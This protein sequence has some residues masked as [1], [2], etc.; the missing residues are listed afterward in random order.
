MADLVA[1][2]PEKADNALASYL[3]AKALLLQASTR[4]LGSFIAKEFVTEMQR[5]TLAL[6]QGLSEQ[7]V[8]A[9]AKFDEASRRF[10]VMAREGGIELAAEY[11]NAL[12]EDVALLDPLF[13]EKHQS[14]VAPFNRASALFD[15]VVSRSVTGTEATRRIFEAVEL[16]R[17][18]ELGMGSVSRFDFMERVETHRSAVWDLGSTLLFWGGLAFL[19]L[20]IGYLV[21]GASAGPAA[22]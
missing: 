4:T 14:L 11:I 6:L 20:R 16:L 1:M 18:T 13:P 15:A 5:G 9:V 22:G 3:A 2:I 8:D 17:E 21:V 12:K 7:G 19:A 10:E